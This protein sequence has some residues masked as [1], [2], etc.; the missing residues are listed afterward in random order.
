MATRQA[1]FAGSWYPGTERDCRRAFEQFEATCVERKQVETPRGGIVPHAGWVFSGR[2]AYNT[3][4]ELAR[5]SD[6]PDTVVLFG[7]HLRPSSPTTI[8]VGGDF[9]TPLGAIPTDK[10]LA[11]A[12]CRRLEVRP[13]TPERH[14]P[15]N[16]TEVQAPMVKHLLPEAR[17]VVIGAPPRPETVVLADAIVELARELGR[18]IVV[19]GSTDLTHYGP[20]YG[21]SPHGLGE[22]AVAWV[23]DEND[24]RWIDLACRLEP[25][26]VIDEALESSNSCCP[27]A[28]AAAIQC[29]RQLGAQRG[30]LLA[31]ATSAD[32]RPDDS[33]V[34]YA[35]IVF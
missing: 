14:S 1:D 27:G 19:I 7:G 2:L 33:F 12:L 30:E 23:R 35:A 9:W 31:Y 5:Q 8:L 34:G 10:E 21:W 26:A 32:V 25:Q 20:N 4:R 11:E 24:R 6:K 13:E 16:T 3:V 28:A 22:P 29:G 15:D 18:R 17:L